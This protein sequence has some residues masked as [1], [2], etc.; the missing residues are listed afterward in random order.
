[1]TSQQ[2]RKAPSAL[3]SGLGG[4]AVV[5]VSEDAYFLVTVDASAPQAC[6]ATHWSQLRAL[7][8][9]VEELYDGVGE[10]PFPNVYRAVRSA[11][12][13]DRAL[14]LALIALDAHH[15][16][17]LRRRACAVGDTLLAD[18]EVAAFLYARLFGVPPP[19]EADV[20]GAMTIASSVG[21]HR[22]GGLFQRLENGGPGS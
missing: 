21:A 4:R 22:L 2:S 7:D 15:T 18:D 5:R 10:L 6:D 9:D 14:R 1:V 17:Q 16:D 11:Y 8:E 20:T 12:Q 3:I 13:R 19:D